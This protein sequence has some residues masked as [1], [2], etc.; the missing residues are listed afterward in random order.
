MS[1]HPTKHLG[2]A[3]AL[4]GMKSLTSR[5]TG[6]TP[7]LVVLLARAAE[8]DLGDADAVEREVELAVAGG[9]GSGARCPTR[10]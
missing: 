5:V 2:A 8:P 3:L 1:L 9:I 6:R 10:P 4:E 7:P